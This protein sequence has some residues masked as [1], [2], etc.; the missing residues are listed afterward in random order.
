MN[1]EEMHLYVCEI[2]SNKYLGFKKNVQADVIKRWIFH[3]LICTGKW[4][5]I[6]VFKISS[7]K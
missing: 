3:S 7:G 2:Q 5:R 1:Y 4:R 6:K